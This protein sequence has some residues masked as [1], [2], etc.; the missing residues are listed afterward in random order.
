LSHREGFG[1]V[2]VCTQL[3]SLDDVLFRGLGREHD[4]GQV[5]VHLT[6]LV[7]DAQAIQ[8]GEHEIQKNE[9]IVTTESHLQS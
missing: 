6:D 3:E 5:A 9:M 2:I 7:T 8:T 4:D 1:D